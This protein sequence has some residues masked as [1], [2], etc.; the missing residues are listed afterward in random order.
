MFAELPTSP[1]GLV[2]RDKLYSEL[3]RLGYE[4]EGDAVLIEGYPLQILP[5]QTAARSRGRA[6]SP[7]DSRRIAEA[8]DGFT[9]E[10]V[11]SRL[12]R[13]K[14]ERRRALAALSFEEKFRL[15]YEMNCL[16]GQVIGKTRAG[17]S[18]S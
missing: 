2:L 12:L 4:S 5:E 10:Q 3:R 15:V 1:G 18:H 9:N 7:H 17:P 16:S 8:D 14:G 6:R 11:L 13:S